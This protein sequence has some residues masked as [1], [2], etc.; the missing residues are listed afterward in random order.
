MAAGAFARDRVAA[1]VERA[2]FFQ[3]VE[4]A[5]VLALAAVNSRDTAEIE[6]WQPAAP[7][8]GSVAGFPS[9]ARCP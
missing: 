5:R 4:K 7:R 6:V 9:A 1:Q 3:Q 8:F 2:R